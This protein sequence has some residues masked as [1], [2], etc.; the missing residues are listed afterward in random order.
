MLRAPPPA[1][2][3]PSPS[4]ALPAA[5]QARF[6]YETPRPPR[7]HTNSTTHS[8]HSLS[9]H[10]RPD[11]KTP[12]SHTSPP[13][14]PNSPPYRPS[15]LPPGPALSSTNS[16]HLASQQS[17]DTSPQCQRRRLPLSVPVTGTF[18]DCR[19]D[20][21]LGFDEGMRWG[22]RVAQTTTLPRKWSPTLPIMPASPPDT[23][24]TLL[25][26]ARRS[27][28]L[29][30]RTFATT[31]MSLRRRFPSG[32]L[33]RLYVHQPLPATHTHTHDRPLTVRPWRCL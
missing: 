16:L 5:H 22:G 1:P 13:L 32:S 20:R 9:T 29:P 24:L 10:T 11:T 8:Q 25:A 6:R 2:R 30:A 17:T 3:L 14:F 27:P 4:A 7:L 23:Q 19:R 15:S 28:V 18:S 26:G 33:R 31:R 21:T 12:P